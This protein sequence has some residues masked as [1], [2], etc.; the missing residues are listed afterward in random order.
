[1]TYAD[2]AALV[3][4]RAAELGADA[5]ARPA[6]GR[7]RRRDASS[8]TSP[9]SPA[10]TRCCWP[11]RATPSG[12]P[13]LRR[14]LPARRRP[15]RRATA[16]AR[17]GPAP[18]RPAPGPR[19]A[20]QHVRLHRLAQAGPALAGQRARQR[21]QHRR[22]PRPPRRPTA[23]SPR[24]RCTTATACRCSP[25]TWSAA[26]RS[27]SPSSRSPTPASGTWPRGAGATSFAGVP[28]HLRP[29]RRRPASPTGAARRCATSPRPAA[30]WTPARVRA[31]AELGRRRGWD[32]FVM[33]GQTEAT[34]RMAYLPP[35]LAAERP[36]AIGVPIPGGAFRLDG[37]G[38]DGV[39]ELV[40]S[41][42]NVM[43]G[44]AE[45]AGRPRP[46]RRAHRA[47]HRRPGP[48]GRRRPVGDRGPARPAR[49]AVRPAPRPRP[50]RAPARRARPAGARP[51]ARRPAVGVH[52]PAARRRAHPP[53]ASLDGHRAARLARVRVVR[54]DELPRDVVGQARLRRA[55]PQHAGR[56]RA[57]EP[58]APAPATAD[59]IRDLYAVLLGRPDATIRRQL[60]RP[61][62]RLAVLRRGLDAAGPGPRHAAARLAA[63]RR[64]WP[65]AR[66]AAQ[67]APLHRADRP[68]GAAARGGRAADPGQPRRPRPAPGRRPRAA[69]GRRL[70]PGPLPARAARPRARGSAASCAPRSPSAVPA[71]AVDRRR[72]PW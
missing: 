2:L 35:D 20:A 34:A 50:G 40:Y 68:V 47:A 63:P 43:M 12:T 33:Y 10:G 17:C 4:A 45:R 48:P 36:E 13:H 55:A 23:R 52:R 31:Y 22:L 51:G 11:R 70:Q 26:P 44:Y 60:R 69:G 57:D 28:V 54:L 59:G 62:R 39:G 32:L 27:C 42:P 18:P 1:M 71:A 46:R 72:R 8:P 64:P 30:G 9:P 24:C 3:E 37:V 21:A 67:P 49:Q 29:A 38:A 41:G 65:L 14:P 19:R 7:Q 6:R 5:P 56:T 58:S 66:H 53:R 25:A 61:R 16:A 15:G